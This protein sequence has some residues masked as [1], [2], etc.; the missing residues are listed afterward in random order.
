MFFM[1][2]F[3]G[4]RRDKEAAGWRDG[5]QLGLAGGDHVRADLGRDGAGAAVNR[6]IDTVITNQLNGI[7]PQ[8]R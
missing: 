3:T 7:V 5:P 8:I 1:F 6:D 4:V 2:L